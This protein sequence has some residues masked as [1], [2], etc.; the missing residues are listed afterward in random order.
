[1]RCRWPPAVFQ[2]LVVGTGGA[3]VPLQL[4][5]VLKEWIEAP[6]IAPYRKI[7]GSKIVEAAISTLERYKPSDLARQD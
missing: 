1:L 4:G 2:S 7:D 3:A 5:G 6:S